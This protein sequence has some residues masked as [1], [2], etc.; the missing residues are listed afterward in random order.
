MNRAMDV[1][2]TLIL[3]LV[4]LVMAA[5]GLIE[6]ALRGLMT[7]G[8]IDPQ[9]QAIVLVAAAV[10]LIVAAL[11]AFGGIL[12]VLIIIFLALLLVHVLMPGLHIPS[13]VHV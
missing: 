11:R 1:V 7:R 10:V 6:G 8:G 9:V 3:R 2:L 12:R 13:S 4:G 5:I